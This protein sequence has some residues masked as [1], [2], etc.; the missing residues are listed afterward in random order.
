MSGGVDALLTD[1]TIEQELN[2]LECTTQGEEDV[3]LNTR[4]CLCE[5]TDP[6]VYFCDDCTFPMC[7][8][9][10]KAHQRLK[11]YSGHS[12]RSVDEVDSKQ[13]T[14]VKQKCLR[15]LV[16]SKHPIKVP[17]IFCNSC[18]ELVCCECVV[19]G[20][21]G[22]KFVGI[23]STT[24]REMEGKLSEISTTVCEVLELFERNLKYVEA[25]EKVTIDRGMKNQEGIK[26]MFD[27][28][29]SNLQMRRDELVAQSEERNSAKLK[30]IWSEKDLLQ[31]TI[32][33]LTTTLRFSERLQMCRNDEEY[34]SLA[35]QAL[36]TLRK[37]RKCS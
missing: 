24:K 1:Y 27:D 2:K 35:S 8:F 5:S 19:E 16:C 15:R 20:H 33:K 7:D 6:V 22:H 18:D 30:V 32:A 31:Q 11:Q 4:C 29:I 13:L 14:S 21:E 36:L 37:M 28:F 9:C 12:V 10:H 3:K 34:L 25:V 17:Q 26:R 23:N